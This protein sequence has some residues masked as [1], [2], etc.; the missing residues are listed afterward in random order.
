MD[1][2]TIVHHIETRI[3]GVK[4]YLDY[5]KEHNNAKD[6]RKRS[7]VYFDEQALLDEINRLEKAL[8]NV[9]AR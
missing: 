2:E 4:A 9:N 1:K 7:P 3:V 8:E 6:V 5:Q